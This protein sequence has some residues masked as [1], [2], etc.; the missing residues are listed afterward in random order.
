MSTRLEIAQEVQAALTARAPVVALESTVIAHGLPH[1]RN[2]EVARDLEALV[3]DAGAVPATIGVVEGKVRIGMPDE[4]IDRFG[5]SDSV[6]KASIRDLGAVIARGGSAA[7]T[8]AATSLLAARA[9]IDVFATGG[10]GGVH[11][12][13]ESS[14]DISADLKA[15]AEVPVTVV[16]AGAKA[17]LDLPRTLEVLETLGVPVIGLRTDQFPAFYTRESGLGLDH[18]AADERD[19]A[20][21]ILAHRALDLTSAVIVCNPPP[22]DAEL[23]AARVDG[24]VERAMREAG[25]AG[26]SGKAVTPWLLTRLAELS[27]G[28]TVETNVA[29]LESN[30]RAAAGLARALKEGDSPTV[31]GF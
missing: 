5:A 27:E 3:R 29:L 30:A 10:I 24:L 2:V 26:V 12:G 14:L 20:R 25:E 8:V 9:G 16:C 17:I 18:V 21:A 4:A 7:T 1:P 23:D 15:L 22:P 11:R 13:G 31:R 19:A 28:R 6:E